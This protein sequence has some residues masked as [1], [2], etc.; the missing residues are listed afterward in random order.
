M[1]NPPQVF[2]RFGFPKLSYHGVLYFPHCLHDMIVL[3]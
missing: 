3:L 2:Y 1:L